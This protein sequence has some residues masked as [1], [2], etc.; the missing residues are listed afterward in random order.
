M[1][2][3]SQENIFVERVLKTLDTLD[4]DKRT[5]LIGGAALAVYAWHL[6]LQWQHPQAVSGPP[7]PDIDVLAD[8]RTMEDYLSG[9][10][11]NLDKFS[12][13]ADPYDTTRKYGEAVYAT[14]SGS[15][16]MLSFTAFATDERLPQWNF[17]DLVG[18]PHKVIV[19]EGR[20]VLRPGPVLMWK[21]L[22]N[23]PKDRDVIDS[24]LNG[25]PQDLIGRIGERTLWTIRSL[26][27]GTLEQDT[28]F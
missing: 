13:R 1:A 14:P 5:L 22:H 2:Y 8:E 25:A 10:Y 4:P 11:G 27:E 15:A 9:R 24:I 12:V 28:L 7:F 23:R 21:A 16:D 26:T 6:G 17:H 20:K 19:L 3:S 18:D